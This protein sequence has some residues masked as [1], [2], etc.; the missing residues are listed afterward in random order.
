MFQPG[1]AGCEVDA[2]AEVE[3]LVHPV[4]GG[5]QLAAAQ[6]E[7]VQAVGGGGVAGAGGVLPP[8]QCSLGLRG[9]VEQ[10]AE[11]QGAVDVDGVPQAS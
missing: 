3:G 2:G 10:V 11:V 7:Q 1:G 8:P 6:V 4:V 9:E 5:A